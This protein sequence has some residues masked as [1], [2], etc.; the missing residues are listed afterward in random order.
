MHCLACVWETVLLV[1]VVLGVAQRE[2]RVVVFKI[3]VDVAVVANV[4]V[5]VAG[6]CAGIGVGVRLEVVVMWLG[7]MVVVVNC[8]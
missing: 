3:M 5:D 1:P 7:E 6:L 8:W 2:W 4:G